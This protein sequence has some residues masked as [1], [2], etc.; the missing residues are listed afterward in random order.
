MQF[1]TANALLQYLFF[2][3]LNFKMKELY[4]GSSAGNGEVEQDGAF[5]H[6]PPYSNKELV[7]KQVTNK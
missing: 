4:V 2:L 1:G 5:C 3:K 7:W 6:T